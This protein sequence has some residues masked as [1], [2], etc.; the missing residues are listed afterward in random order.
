MGGVAVANVFAQ[1]TIDSNIK[2]GVMLHCF[3]DLPTITLPT[4]MYTG[5]RDECCGGE[6]MWPMYNL[7]QSQHKA[8]ANMMDA[9]HIKPNFK[10]DWTAFVNAWFQ[11]Y[12]VGDISIYY[13]MIYG[14]GTDSLCFGRFVPMKD[15]CEAT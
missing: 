15:D 8:Y 9:N 5:T 13:N 2:A 11:I 4:A 12:L 1:A 6:K 14:N 10:T 7:L 3:M